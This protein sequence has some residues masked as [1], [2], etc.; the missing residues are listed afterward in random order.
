MIW[1][2]GDLKQK[3]RQV[4]EPRYKRKLKDAEVLEIAQNLTNFMETFYRLRFKNYGKQT[5]TV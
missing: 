2:D 5:E 3:V 4:F 1:L